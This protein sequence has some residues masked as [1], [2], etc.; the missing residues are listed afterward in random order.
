MFWR[1][2]PRPWAVAADWLVTIGAA[3]AFVLIFEAEVAKPYRIPSASMEPTLHCA[4]PEDYCRARVSDRI[5]ANR[6][7]F[8]FRDPRRGE[9]VVFKTPPAT[10][11]AC[12]R[13]G[14][15]V[16][17]VIGLPGEKI[18][19][20]NGRILV[21]GKPLSEPYVDPRDRGS[22]T[23][24]FPRVPADSY[25][26]MGDNRIHS[27]DSR[28]WGAVPRGNLIGPVLVRYWPLWRIPG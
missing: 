27:C 1:R 8:R 24:T 16:K 25:L 5:V 9:I 7:A 22:E 11:A 18:S 23:R 19:E 13:G 14:V 3:I 12:G 4:H 2:L 17:R 10:E 6:L 28:T 15:F 26:L 21:E 20:A